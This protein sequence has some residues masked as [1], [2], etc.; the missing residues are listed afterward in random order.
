MQ[1]LN[2]LDDRYAFI[3]TGAATELVERIEELA[4]LVRLRNTN[5]RL[6]NARDW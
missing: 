6:T 4:R 2:R 3:E 5:E 1:E